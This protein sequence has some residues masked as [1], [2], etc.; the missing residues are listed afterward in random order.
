M[1]MTAIAS[2]L[3]VAYN[4]STLCRRVL[5][6][7]D[8]GARQVSQASQP[9]KQPISRHRIVTHVQLHGGVARAQPGDSFLTEVPAEPPSEHARNTVPPPAEKERVAAS[10]AV[11]S[12][13]E[14]AHDDA[15]VHECG[16]APTLQAPRTQVSADPSPAGR[17]GALPRTPN[18][19]TSS[20]SAVAP[21]RHQPAGV[22]MQ[23]QPPLGSRHAPAGDARYDFSRRNVP[24]VVGDTPNGRVGGGQLAG[25]NPAASSLSRGQV[26]EQDRPAEGQAPSVEEDDVGPPLWRS[27]A[28]LGQDSYGDKPLGQEAAVPPEEIPSSWGSLVPEQHHGRV[29]GHPSCI[30]EES[31]AW[32]GYISEFQPATPP[33][34]TTPTGLSPGSDV[35]VEDPTREGA[36][37]RSMVAAAETL[38]GN[39]IAHNET[40]LALAWEHVRADHRGRTALKPT[41]P[42]KD[43]KGMQPQSYGIERGRAE[44][45]GPGLPRD[46]VGV[47][48]KNSS[49]GLH[50]GGGARHGGLALDS[51]YKS[52]SAELETTKLS[53]DSSGI[54]GSDADSTRTSPIAGV[55]GGGGK[56]AESPG[57]L[58]DAIPLEVRP[59]SS[60]LAP[61]IE[62]G[63]EAEDPY[64]EREWDDEGDDEGGDGNWSSW[65]T[66]GGGVGDPLPSSSDA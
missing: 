12:S 24:H 47:V 49:E 56:Q 17:G 61:A 43:G 27:M 9:A 8:D 14:A 32:S 30:P 20:S 2:Q 4:L 21:R 3:D 25:S 34:T 51:E 23:Q 22:P 37:T 19:T 57:G 52:D 26:E 15:R 29:G 58:R 64:G 28:P 1:A 55:G 46:E 66:G 54:G 13:R 65:L 10:V 35:G 48:S 6:S 36:P 39:E 45:G 53:A 63:A 7:A 42:P 60:V 62:P 59:P 16:E 40:P 31:S 11:L 18:R 41:T 44:K 50:S 33:E 5:S 38:R